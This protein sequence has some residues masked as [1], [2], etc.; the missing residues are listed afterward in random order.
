MS[1]VDKFK[2]VLALVLALALVLLIFYG[3]YKIYI[4]F[5]QETCSKYQCPDDYVNDVS[6]KDTECESL[7]CKDTCCNKSVNCE[8]SWSNFGACS[9]DCGGGTQTRTYT[10]TTQPQYGGTPCPTSQ[11][12]Q[13]SQPCNTQACATCSSF[14]CTGT[15]SPRAGADD[16]SCGK[17]QCDDS[18]KDLCCEN[19]QGDNDASGGNEGDDIGVV[20]NATC[21]TVPE[22]CPVGYLY[23]TDSAGM[24]CNGL[25]C[26]VGTGGVDLDTCC[27]QGC[28]SPG[29][30]P[31]GYTGSL[32]DTL[33]VGVG[34]ITG[35]Q[36]AENYNGT[37]RYT[38][39]GAGE[40]Y[41]LDGCGQPIDCVVTST[42]YSLCSGDCGSRGTKTATYTIGVE[43][44]YGGN[45]CP[46]TE[47]IPCDTRA[48]ATCN[49]YQCPEGY[50]PKSGIG[51]VSCGN[52]DCNIDNRD[53]CCEVGQLPEEQDTELPICSEVMTPNKIPSNSSLGNPTQ[54]HSSSYEICSELCRGL[55]FCQSF[56]Y[57]VVREDITAAASQ[58][59]NRRNC[60]IGRTSNGIVPSGYNS[61]NL[62]SSWSFYPKCRVSQS[63][64]LTPEVQ[65][66]PQLPLC[67][68]VKIPNKQALGRLSGTLET[69]D[70]G[71]CIDTCFIQ[72]NNC[73][74]FS[75]NK[76]RNR[77]YLYED[78]PT[79]LS[80]NTN[81]DYYPENCQP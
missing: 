35:I 25:T 48:C 15:Y 34:D 56:A 33:P 3:G 14:D 51:D 11:G 68:D 38:C 12:S 70:V 24:E 54:M 74:S 31:T 26:D 42:Q 52:Y 76:R 75:Y 32:P 50:I 69:E 47:E 23:K 55:D 13:D 37:P 1:K 65:E 20:A 27:E 28:T 62:F 16:V 53:T 29:T 77:C 9:H 78:N 60:L 5:Y 22:N 4:H 45:P 17:T 49:S 21:N 8:G 57:G 72:R 79:G 10:V 43:A 71:T 30:M 61:D 58:S 44:Q 59:A 2:K 36:C 40:E 66:S 46:T 64:G 6:K 39:N 67:N 19:I 63:G 18:N 41:I 81:Y 7:T 80:N 73:N